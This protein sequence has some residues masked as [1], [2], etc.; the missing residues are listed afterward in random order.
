MA[1]NRIKLSE[2]DLHKIIR[3]SV[4]RIIKENIETPSVVIDPKEITN[5]LLYKSNGR[6]DTILQAMYSY[7]HLDDPGDINDGW[8]ISQAFQM[9]GYDEDSVSD[10]DW[11]KMKKTLRLIAMYLENYGQFD[12]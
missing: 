10:E 9:M 11:E 2:S 7:A 12:D 3:E 5:T 4:K 1:K 6:Y 8:T